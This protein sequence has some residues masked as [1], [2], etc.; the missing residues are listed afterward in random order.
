MVSGGQE[1]EQSFLKGWVVWSWPWWEHK[2][3]SQEAGRDNVGHLCW[4][5]CGGTK[6]SKTP[7]SSY[8]PFGCGCLFARSLRGIS[9]RCT[10]SWL[11]ARDFQSLG[12]AGSRTWCVI[13]NFQLS[14]FRLCASELSLFQWLLLRREAGRFFCPQGHH[15]VG[16]TSQGQITGSCTHVASPPLAL[17][18]AFTGSSDSIR[19]SLHVH[20]YP[21][22]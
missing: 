4:G 22:Y 17:H 16:H 1:K 9:P 11:P 8:A 7:V 5:L 12:G 21:L 3:S 6:S 19:G 13:K 14:T 15:G 18:I 20:V 2:G 10:S